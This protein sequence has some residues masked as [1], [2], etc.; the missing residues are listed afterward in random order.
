MPRIETVVRVFVASP[1]DVLAERE[2]VEEVVQELNTT[3]SSTIG[4]RLHVVRWETDSR[5]G[6]STDAQQV[7]NEQ[8]GDDYDIFLAIVWSRMGT[9]T[10]RADSGTGEEF[11]HAL[12][13]SRA[14]P[15]SVRIMVYF[16]DAPVPP[17]QVDIEQLQR[18]RRFQEELRDAGI[19]FRRF[20][21]PEEFGKLLRI[22]LSKEAQSFPASSG[23]GTPP[24]PP[25]DHG[26][27]RSPQTNILDEE[28]GF[29]DLL[30]VATG[31]MESANAV[32]E[33]LA[34]FVQEFAARMSTNAEELRGLQATPSQSLGATKSIVNRAAA[35][36]DGFAAQID[37]DLPVFQR[38]YS[39][40]MESYGRAAALLTDFQVGDRD[41]VGQL[42]R[43]LDVIGKMRD[44]MT[45][46]RLHMRTFRDT[47][48]RMPRLTTALN[49][50]KRRGLEAMDRFD[51]QFDVAVNL[52]K[53][54]ERLIRG[55]LPSGN[56]SG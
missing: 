42:R 5:P 9:P 53:E 15:D 47:I 46:T 51:R 50:A 37:A 36:L 19:L 55:L 44:A 31:G 10:P 48:G 24:S 20:I 4:V 2:A 13:R 45:D 35:D 56:S 17:S 41:H 33:R 52:A 43:S 40:A 1:D 27:D 49:R 7:I 21:E 28:D 26:S 23:T 39:Q 25:E 29:L 30:E 16:K 11:R 8:I 6:V 12:S 3:W 54:T 38:S 32:A 18:V 14:H 22:H 34:E